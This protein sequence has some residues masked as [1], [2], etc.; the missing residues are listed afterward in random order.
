MRTG[1]QIAAA[2]CGLTLLGGVAAAQP[3]YTVRSEVD[4]RQIGVEDQ[5]QLTLT[6]EGSGAPG[7]VAVPALT[8]LTVVGGPF[9]STQVSIVNGQMTQS[10]SWTYVLAPQQEGPAEVGVVTAGAQTAPAITLQVSPGQLRSR[11]PRRRSDPFGSDPFGSMLGRRRPQQ[12]A[13]PKV[14]VRVAPSRRTL[15]VGEPLLLT[16]ELYTQTAVSDL[17]FQEA[18]QFP[19]F[20]AEELER[21]QTTPNGEAAV[22]DGESYRRFPV[23]RKMLFP[24]KAG[25]LEIPSATFRIGIPSRGFFDRGQAVERSTPPVTIRVQALPDAPGF[26]GAV[27]SFA[28]TATLDR[29]AVPLG[30]AAL[31]RLKIQG[32][33]NLKWIDRLP[34]VEVPGAK[35]YPPQAKSDLTV[36]PQGMRG[37]RSWEFVVVPETSGTLEIPSVAFAYFNPK[38]DAIVTAATQ[39]LQLL[40]EGGTV[41]PGA[42]VAPAV[43]RGDTGALPIRADLDASVSGLP[44]LGGRAVALFA[45]LVVLG[46]VG[47][48]GGGLVRRTFRRVGGRTTPVRSV[49]AAL[50]DIDRAGREGMAKEQAA[51]LLDKALHEAFGDLPEDDDSEKARAVRSLLSEIHFVRYAPQLGDYSENLKALAARAGEAVKRWA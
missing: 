14:Q 5:V 9:Q 42:P 49:R 24:T 25:S 30:E 7:A 43:A 34:D 23:L 48:W 29:D 51:A 50:S 41:A 45:A 32:T 38:A 37:S 15:R 8:N 11:E 19:G 3:S 33:G 27:G 10:K 16:Y 26:T 44:R 2:A 12:R 39:P 36:T 4:A 35:V 1:R 47:L 22:L 40:V 18:P 13:A 17:N 20:W 46:H 21:P 28:A 31:L 6:L